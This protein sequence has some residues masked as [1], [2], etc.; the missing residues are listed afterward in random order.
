[1]SNFGFES[2]RTIKQTGTNAKISE[3][4]CAVGLAQLDRIDAIKNKRHNILNSYNTLF[5]NYNL[6]IKTQEGL[7]SFVPA[8]LYVLFNQGD[9]GTLFEQLLSQGIETRR[10]YWPLIR[11]FP[12]FK[13][14][15]LTASLNF[16]HAQVVSSQGLAL[17]FHGLLKSTDI[18][19]TVST[20][21]K[22][23]CKQVLT[24]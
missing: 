6:K 18:E 9:T 1:M 2:G 8:S 7:D 11:G 19:R 12:A 4:H 13:G 15:T 10:L 22:L 17:P 14:N 3:Y 21:S 5:K 20:L 16:K 24:K 23:I